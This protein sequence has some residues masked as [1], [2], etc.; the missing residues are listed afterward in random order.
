MATGTTY[1]VRGTADEADNVAMSNWVIFREVKV[2]D[3][4]GIYLF[5]V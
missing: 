5:Q 3:H 4:S 2:D 1:E